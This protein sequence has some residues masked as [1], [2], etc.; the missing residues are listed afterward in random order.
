MKF[1]RSSLS[2]NIKA[3]LLFFVLFINIYVESAE[4]LKVNRILSKYS[5]ALGKTRNSETK[6]NANAYR[7]TRLSSRAWRIMNKRALLNFRDKLEAFI[8]GFL[9][10]LTANLLNLALEDPLVKTVVKKAVNSCFNVS[11]Q[12]YERLRSLK[13]KEIN[14]DPTVVDTVIGQGK[15]QLNNLCGELQTIK[16]LDSNQY[17]TLNVITGYISSF[18]SS[19]NSFNKEYDDFKKKSEKLTQ[20]VNS[21]SDQYRKNFATT[22]ASTRNDNPTFPVVKMLS[23]GLKE[24]NIC[25]VTEQCQS[26]GPLDQVKLIFSGGLYFL[27]CVKDLNFTDTVWGNIKKKIGGFFKD[28]GFKL[29]ED[30]AKAIFPGALIGLVVKFVIKYW[31]VMKSFV[32]NFI[33]SFS[34]NDAEADLATKN[35][36][37]EVG[38]IL[39]GL[40]FSIIGGGRRRLKKLRK[41]RKF[42][43]AF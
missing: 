12:E 19:D 16:N 15:T 5:T 39:G 2:N 32:S 4:N 27:E 30:L 21:L 13:L 1:I 33:N 17:S 43:E 23:D 41:F 28:L 6:K 24:K 20:S 3:M 38:S 8:S 18:F 22:L 10:S 25:E 34:N 26:L 36:Y 11:V 31:R 14:C 7:F 35:I 29:L 42:N 37:K 40:L 9:K